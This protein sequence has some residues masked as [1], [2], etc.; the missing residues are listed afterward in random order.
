MPDDDR[1]EIAQLTSGELDRYAN[2]LTRC[3]KALDTRAPIRFR[4][5]HELAEVRAEQD[6]RARTGQSAAS[7]PLRRR[8]SDRR[9]AGA[10][11][12]RACRTAH[13]PPE[14]VAGLDTACRGARRL[15]RNVPPAAAARPHR[16]VGGRS[17]RRGRAR[18]PRRWR[19]RP[20]PRPGLARART[21]ARDRDSGYQDKSAAGHRHLRQQE[22]GRGRGNETRVC[23]A[24]LR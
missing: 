5:Q 24:R 16:R 8:R 3:L 9:R 15:L 11:P 18:W 21:A 17:S 7:P 10:D 6:T 14:R 19:H 22:R 4:V 2:Q 12:A 1:A 13:G 20:G 23:L